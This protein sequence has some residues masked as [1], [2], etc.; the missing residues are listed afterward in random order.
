MFSK[1]TRI[2]SISIGFLVL[3]GVIAACSGADQPA[4]KSRSTDATDPGTSTNEVTSA[5][6]ACTNVAVHDDDHCNDGVYLLNG[7]ND[8]SCSALNDAAED[9]KVGLTVQ[10]PSKLSK[11]SPARFSFGKTSAFRSPLQRVLDVLEPSA[12]AHGRTDGDVY[13]LVFEDASC[14]EVVRA[15]TKES[16]LTLDADS[17]GK[18]AQA[19]GPITLTV[20]LATLDDS[21]VKDGTD[22]VSSKPATFE[23]K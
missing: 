20:V 14:K 17:W 19:K 22:A 11:S 8:E 7:I 13:M 4:A 16:S 6:S 5:A 23:I 12:H 21:A 1:V 3:P 15:F 10:I 2:A 9:A 18:L